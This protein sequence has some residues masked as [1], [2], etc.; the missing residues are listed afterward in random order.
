MSEQIVNVLWSW[1]RVFLAAALTYI[2]TAL[3]GG[4]GIDWRGV[5][6]AGAVSLL[7]VVINWLN[8]NDPRY[9][10]GFLPAEA[11]ADIGPVARELRR[12]GL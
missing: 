8:A 7:P 3:T 6:I 12:R 9:G 1:A 5:L 2:L 4:G 10:R 11:L